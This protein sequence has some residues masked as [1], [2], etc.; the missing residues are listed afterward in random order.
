MNGRSA[1]PASTHNYSKSAAAA[2]KNVAK[3]NS[4]QQNVSKKI[5]GLKDLQIET[6]DAAKGRPSLMDIDNK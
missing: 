3:K 5:Q 2:T 6:Y 1:A 4:F